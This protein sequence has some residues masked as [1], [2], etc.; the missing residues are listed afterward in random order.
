MTFKS[1]HISVSINRPADQVY[2][3]AS[4]PENLPQ[5]AAVTGVTH[6]TNPVQCV[7]TVAQ[8]TIEY[9]IE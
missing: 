1:L 9:E 3:F 4:N 5:W 7:R 2:E 6:F 8:I